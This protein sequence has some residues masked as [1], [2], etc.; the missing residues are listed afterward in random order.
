[1]AANYE[2]P[3]IL[4]ERIEEKLNE[5][6]ANAQQTPNDIGLQRGAFDEQLLQPHAFIGFE[7]R[8]GFEG[9]SRQLREQQN[10]SRHVGEKPGTP[11]NTQAIEDHPARTSEVR[12]ESLPS[13]LLLW[14]IQVVGLAAAIIFGVFSVFSWIDAQAA[15]AQADTAN[16]LALT[17]LCASSANQ[18]SEVQS[19]CSAYASSA[20]YMDTLNAAV[21]SLLPSIPAATSTT[22]APSTSDAPFT[23][24]H[25]PSSI[26]AAP[27]TSATSVLSGSSRRDHF[28]VSHVGAIIAAPIVASTVLITGLTFLAYRS[29][30][31]RTRNLHGH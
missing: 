29:R 10:E 20:A 9:L 16:L 28:K 19:L 18:N 26:S 30:R 25:A 23:L 21:G 24:T 2:D 31:N 7:I 14:F 6:S 17:A 15:K 13:I 4:H 12:E 11:M 27:S 5:P 1:M 8:K 3:R 22:P